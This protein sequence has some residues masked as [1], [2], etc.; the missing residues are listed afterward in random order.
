VW[1][2][3]TPTAG[4]FAVKAVSFSGV[5]VTPVWA[6]EPSATVIEP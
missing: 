1:S 6:V 5:V 2:A 4:P 3:V